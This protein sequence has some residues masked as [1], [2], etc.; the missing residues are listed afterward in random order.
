MEASGTSN[1]G[2]VIGEFSGVLRGE[3]GVGADSRDQPLSRRCRGFCHALLGSFRTFAPFTCNLFLIKRQNASCFRR[4]FPLPNLH[5]SE[6]LATS[7]YFQDVLSRA[8]LVAGTEAPHR[9]TTT[10]SSFNLPRSLTRALP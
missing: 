6:W 5:E 10:E 9:N 3:N 2:W 7:P 1:L 4:H 8:K